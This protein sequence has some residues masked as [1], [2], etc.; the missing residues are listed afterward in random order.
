MTV[1]VLIFVIVVLAVLLNRTVLKLL[2]TILN[3]RL[4]LNST[5]QEEAEK[6]VRG[7]Q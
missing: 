5:T 2:V 4:D 3:E 1:L 7:T 6:M